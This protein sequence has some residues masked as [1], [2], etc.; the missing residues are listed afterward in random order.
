[1]DILVSPVLHVTFLV[2]NTASEYPAIMQVPLL[3]WFCS[4]AYFPPSLSLSRDDVNIHGENPPILRDNILDDE[5]L[6]GE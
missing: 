4:L 2:E 6:R 3:R 1:M 5:W